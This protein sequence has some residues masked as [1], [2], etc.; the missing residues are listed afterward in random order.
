MLGNDTDAD[1]DTLTALLAGGP[2]NGSLTLNSDGGF[3]YTPNAGFNGAD[4]FTYRAND[5]TVDGNI[6]AV[7]IEVT[8]SEPIGSVTAL[9]YK[10]K[11]VQHVELAWQNF[12]GGTVEIYRDGELLT[13]QSGNDGLYD[14]NIGVKGG[15]QTYL[16]EVCEV[17]RT[18]C[19]Q[20]SV[21]F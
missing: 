1:G 4:G 10:V 21:T 5:G 8:G 19:A 14:D 6:A 2:A 18:S 15:G 11:G 12:V 3:T 20:D 9:P 17:D 16:Y 7:S 13:E